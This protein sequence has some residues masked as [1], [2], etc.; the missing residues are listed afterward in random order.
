MDSLNQPAHVT[1]VD[2]SSLML[3]H[4][5]QILSNRCKSLD[6]RWGDISRYPLPM[7]PLMRSYLPMF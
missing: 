6:L 7:T 2:I 4:A 3:T 5:Q 1:G